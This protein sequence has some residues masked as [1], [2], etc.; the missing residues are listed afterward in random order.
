MPRVKLH[1]I[2]RTS[3][4]CMTCNSDEIKEIR[5]MA[6]DLEIPERE[7]LRLAV[8]A[9]IEKYR[10]TPVEEIRKNGIKVF[11]NSPESLRPE[12]AS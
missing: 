7:I 5:K 3:R 12:G 6:I 2:P 4:L 10:N 8:L 9:L 11:L 1:V